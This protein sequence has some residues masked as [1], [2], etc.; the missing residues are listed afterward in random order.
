MLNVVLPCPS[1]LIEDCQ[2]LVKLP[3]KTLHCVQPPCAINQSDC[4]NHMLQ[5]Q[6]YCGNC[7]MICYDYYYGFAEYSVNVLCK[8]LRKDWVNI[9]SIP[10][11]D[12]TVA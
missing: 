2:G 7:H 1:P 11:W 8:P 12:E 5:P 9:W 3:Y 6:S 10:S 4:S